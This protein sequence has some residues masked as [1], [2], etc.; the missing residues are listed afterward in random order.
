[1][2]SGLRG[3]DDFQII[4]LRDVRQSHVA[5]LIRPSRAASQSAQTHH[6]GIEAR[7]PAGAPLRVC[8]GTYERARPRMPDERVVACGGGAENRTPV[9][10]SPPGSISRLSHNLTFGRGDTV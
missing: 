10:D 3:R 9:H 6:F 2:T 7:S 1:M 8:Q 4:P 5:W